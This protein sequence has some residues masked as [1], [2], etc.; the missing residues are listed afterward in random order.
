MEFKQL[1][2]FAAVVDTGSVHR[3]AER[4]FRTA[5]AVSVALRKLEEEMG[6]PLFDRSERDHHRLTASGKL[7]YSYTVRILAMRGEAAASIKD[8]AKRRRGNLRL[9]MHDSISLYLLP[10]LM[11][12]FNEAQPGVKTEVVC[13]NSE[14]LLT[15][16]DNRTIELALMGDAPE[17]PQLERHFIMQD[18][19]VL[20]TSPRHRLAGL[21][22]VHVRDLAGEFL[23][24]QGTKSLLRARIVQALQESDTPFN[25]CVENI[26]IEAIKGMVVQDLGIGFV[27]LMCV[28]EAAA[29][30]NLV[31]IRVGGV[32]SEWNLSLVHRQSHS[33]SPAA[34][35]FTDISLAITQPNAE[36]SENA[37]GDR[38]E[39]SSV[40]VNKRRSFPHH[41]TR[42]IYC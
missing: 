23:I 36:D 41:S 11:H 27:P 38:M 9:G 17:R 33:L 4:V 22:Q 19:L 15:A 12:T 30:G 2:M 20:I 13:G 26:G 8:L 5:P 31:T 37:L 39:R 7:L 40:L 34:R 3:G 10:S 18:E 25:V 35:A 6:G 14:R 16:L 42:A 32:P 24:L 1:E 21:K 29:Q 28:S